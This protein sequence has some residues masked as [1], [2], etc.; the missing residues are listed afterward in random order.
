VETTPATQ[1]EGAAA[2]VQAEAEKA[3]EAVEQKVEEAAK[4]Q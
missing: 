2:A 4:P 3:P 1:V